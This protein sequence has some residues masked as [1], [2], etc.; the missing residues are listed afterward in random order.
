MVRKDEVTVMF[1]S[2]GSFAQDI[3][4]LESFPQGA[5]VLFY[6]EVENID[7]LYAQLTK[8]VEIT[9]ELETTWYGM[10]EF[11]IK[12]CNGY[13]IGFGENEKPSN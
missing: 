2:S 12:D 1:L 10:R 6:I 11:Y 5:S 8:Q 13:M 3:P 9:K 7:E 4:A